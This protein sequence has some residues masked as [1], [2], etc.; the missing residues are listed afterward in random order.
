MPDNNTK[1]TTSATRSVPQTVREWDPFT[2][3]QRDMDELFSS[4]RGGFWRS[5]VGHTA[6]DLE[7]FWRRRAGQ[8]LAPAV[9]IAE[10]DKQYEIT[11][12]LPGL[13]PENV[14]VKLSNGVL[15]IKGEKKEEKEETKEGYHLSERRFGSFQRSFGVP[16]GIDAE[17]ISADFKN[18]VLT[19]T[20]PKTAEVQQKEK[21]I[22]IKSR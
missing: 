13:Q 18:G 22:A 17:K 3:L 2:S 12:E 11:A 15:T 8:A 21:K 5:P 1:I 20:M 19:I 4:L 6:S 10:T 9:D 16:E 14:D 7:P